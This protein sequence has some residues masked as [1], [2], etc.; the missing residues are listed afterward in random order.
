[1][2]EP[3]G[4][5]GRRT[6]GGTEFLVLMS[7]EPCLRQDV[8]MSDAG[9]PLWTGRGRT[10]QY[11][12]Q[13]SMLV[14]CAVVAVFVGKDWAWAPFA[15]TVVVVAAGAVA[16]AVIMRTA[17]TALR[18]TEEQLQL[19]A[20]R[21]RRRNAVVVPGYVA[22]GVGFGLIAGSFRSYWPAVVIGTM[23]VLTSVVLPLVLLPRLKRRADELRAR[24]PDTDE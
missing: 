8:S 22:I 24:Q 13:A 19:F 9:G 16:N 6:A 1:M 7:V 20:A 4:R 3:G 15:T 17:I 12:S 21:R 10:L 2:P 5:I 18:P 23:I 14:A 11:I